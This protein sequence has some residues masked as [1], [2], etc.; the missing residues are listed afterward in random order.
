LV[1]LGVRNASWR[2]G[3][4]LTVTG[5]VAAA[6][7]LIVAVD[8]FKRDT[9]ATGPGWSG[10]GG[11]ALIGESV[12][13]MV[14]DPSTPEGREA[15]GLSLGSSG[16]DDLAGVDLIAARLR[17]GDDTSC[18]NLY[19]PTRPR[20]VGLSDRFIDANRFRFSRSIAASDSE[21]RNPWLAAGTGGD[22]AIPAIADA[23][24]LDT[25]SAS[26]GDIIV[27]T[28]TPRGRC[29][30][31]VAALSDRAARGLLIWTG[32]SRGVP[33]VAAIASS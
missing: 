6:V 1:R 30:C 27:M 25:C 21:R 28:A 12:V 18:L 20:V 10:S 22:G 8:A 17:P 3:R 16:S 13:P 32:V 31:I 19:Q 15:L 9:R 2:P 33:E 23:T 26:V 11:F 5:L 14:H 4:S 29:V 7:F 24:W